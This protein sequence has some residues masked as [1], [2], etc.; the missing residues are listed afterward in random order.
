MR[1]L[2]ILALAALALA[3]SADGTATV[4]P[5]DNSVGLEQAIAEFA[6]IGIRCVHRE[7]P[8]FHACA[9]LDGGAAC[10]ISDDG[11][12]GVCKPLRDGRLVCAEIENDVC[13]Q[14]DD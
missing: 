14:H 8:P 11:E 7:P 12:L 2:S 6:A 1:R 3:C 13:E 9:G 10:V 4:S 5:R